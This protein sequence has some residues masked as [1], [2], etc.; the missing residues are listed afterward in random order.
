[1]NLFELLCLDK[2]V[3]QMQERREKH[4]EAC[5]TDTQ[6]ADRFQVNLIK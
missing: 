3:P 6:T 1:M 2:E 5:F 4:F